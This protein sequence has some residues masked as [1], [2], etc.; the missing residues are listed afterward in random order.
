MWSILN[1]EICDFVKCRDVYNDAVEWKYEAIKDSSVENIQKMKILSS[2]H[3]EKINKLER[4][5]VAIKEQYDE[6]VD[7]YISEIEAKNKL[8]DEQMIIRKYLPIMRQ[9]TNKNDDIHAGLTVDDKL[10]MQ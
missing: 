4:G 7:K 8:L 5:I 10:T 9:C 3:K 1:E 6:D 2:K